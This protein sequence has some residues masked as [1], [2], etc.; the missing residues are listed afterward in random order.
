MFKS[1]ANRVG[2]FLGQAGPQNTRRN[3]T[4]MYFH[5][6]S[7]YLSCQLEVF[8][9]SKAISNWIMV[10]RAS[11]E[12]MSV[13]KCLIGSLLVALKLGNILSFTLGYST[14]ALV[15]ILQPQF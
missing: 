7:V 15:N 13:Y 1:R 8:R 12:Q 14:V 4:T 2:T 6:L 9:S 5:E 11:M 3:E 10:R